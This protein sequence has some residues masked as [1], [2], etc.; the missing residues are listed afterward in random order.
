MAGTTQVPNAAVLSPSTIKAMATGSAL[1]S[2]AAST[3]Q[4]AQA[5]AQYLASV[6]VLCTAVTAVCLAEIIAGNEEPQ[7]VQG[8][9]QAATTIQ[10]AAQSFEEVGTS[11]ATVL[12]DFVK[13]V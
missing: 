10:Q 13:L 5:G 12:S 1:Q 7:W 3:S 11:A 6:T 8:L 2:V 4:A 9:Q